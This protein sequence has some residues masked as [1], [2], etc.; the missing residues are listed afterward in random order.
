MFSPLGFWNGVFSEAYGWN[1]LR[2]FLRA[3]VTIRYVPLRMY[4]TTSLCCV[5]QTK[6]AE[7]LQLGDCLSPD[8]D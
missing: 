1:V 5:G 3:E 4:S 8:K 6:V 7:G 2:V